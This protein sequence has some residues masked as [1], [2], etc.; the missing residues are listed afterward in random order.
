MNN[1]PDLLSLKA[2]ISLDASMGLKVG[3]TSAIIGTFFYLILLQFFFALQGKEIIS[4][5]NLLLFIHNDP[6]IFIYFN[7]LTFL[8]APYEILFGSGTTVHFENLLWFIIPWIAAGFLTG[9]IY[10]PKNENGLILGS[11]IPFL[12]GIAGLGILLV[13]IIGI[14]SSEDINAS[15]NSS[16]V[17]FFALAIFLLFV[18]M[19]ICILAALLLFFPSLYIGYFFGKKFNNSTYP[20]LMMARPKIQNN[21]APN[22]LQEAKLPSIS[23]EKLLSNK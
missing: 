16:S 15:I 3:F 6:E 17:I 19:I 21:F 10:G 13:S 18:A 20:L 1:D 8:V 4:D 7:L 2:P 12:I 9:V 22:V 11:I 23:N 5:Q 14:L